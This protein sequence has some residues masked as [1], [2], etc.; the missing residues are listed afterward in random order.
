M[1]STGT[2]G[3]KQC[4]SLSFLPILLSYCILDSALDMSQHNPGTT[5]KTYLLKWYFGAVQLSP[6]VSGGW[7]L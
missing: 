3:R 4:I 7:S 5:A 2:E 1:K 6:G